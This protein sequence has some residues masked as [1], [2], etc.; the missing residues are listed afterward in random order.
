LNLDQANISPHRGPTYD[1]EHLRE[2]K[3]NTPTS[4][5]VVAADPYDAD[6]SMDM[7]D[8]SMMSVDSVDVFGES[9]SN[10]KSYVLSCCFGLEA[11]ES[12]IPS[13]SS[14]KVAKERRGLLRKTGVSGEDD[15][16]SL[17]VAR[18]S[19]DQGPHPESRLM[20]EEDEVGDA[21]D[22]L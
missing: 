17:S 19:E 12:I 14:I 11:S 10:R 1:Q 9:L 18:R 16:I 2:L 21:D 8:V 13:E 7:G 15:F 4:R 20:R 6:M 3:A 5:S 22:G